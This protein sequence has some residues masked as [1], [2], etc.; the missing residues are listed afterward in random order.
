M[1]QRRAGVAWA[2]GCPLIRGHPVVPIRSTPAKA[3]REHAADERT[4][5]VSR[6]V[7]QRDPDVIPLVSSAISRSCWRL[8]AR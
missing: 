2:D 6:A 8:P 7:P 4:A 3:D 5:G 1:L